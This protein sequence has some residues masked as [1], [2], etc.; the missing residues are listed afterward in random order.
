METEAK[1]KLEVI[2]AHIAA[3]IMNNTLAQS[4]FVAV[5]DNVSIKDIEHTL[6]RPARIKSNYIFKDVASFD[7]YYGEHNNAGTRVFYKDDEHGLAVKA[8]FDHHFSSKQ[9][10]TDEPIVTQTPSWNSHTATLK[11]SYHEEY[12]RLLDGNGYGFSQLQFAEFVEDN[13]PLFNTP[14]G[15]D[16]LEIAQELKGAR[17]AD[18]RA[19]KRLA[20]GRVNFEYVE[21]LS[22]KTVRGDI[23]IPEDILFFSPI[24]EGEAPVLL[25]AKFR[26]RLDDSGKVSFLYKLMTDRIERQ[27]R[28]QLIASLSERLVRPILQL[29]A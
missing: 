16:M 18:F 14:T 9:R 8:V 17:K 4:H 27:A 10:T 12:K 25:P 13:L 5:P 2:V 15:A 29:V 23:N 24:Y 1:N 3:G 19:G 20:D 22:A 21:E 26:W 28:E 7:V 11:L 6:A